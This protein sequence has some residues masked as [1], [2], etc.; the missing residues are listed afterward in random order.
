MAWENDRVA[1]RIYGE[2]LKK[3]PSAMSSNGIDVW[4]KRT[5]NLVVEKWYAKGHDA[6]HV[7]T[8]E[9]ADFFDVG[10]TLGVGG[11]A[12]WRG[13]SLQRGD[14]FKAWKTLAEGPIRAAFE[15]RYDPWGGAGL[16]VSEVKRVVI[17]AGH[18]LY[19]AESRFRVEGGSAAAIPYATGVV[20]R[21]GMVGT[22]SRARP[23]AWVAGWG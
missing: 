1:F 2:G 8:G 16:R 12:L 5:R 6:Y 18:H 7:D 19:R 3:T 10:E 21:P 22:T 23:W 13:D 9:G 20:K 4:L 15:L 17:D 14:N 11:T